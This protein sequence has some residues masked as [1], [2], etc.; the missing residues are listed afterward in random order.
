M[1]KQTELTDQM[2]KKL[3]SGRDIRTMRRLKKIDD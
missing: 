1:K 3:S 2:K